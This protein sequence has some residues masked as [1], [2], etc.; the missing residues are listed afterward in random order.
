[1]LLL[2]AAV[3]LLHHLMALAQ[4]IAQA[5]LV[6][7]GHYYVYARNVVE[8]RALFDLEAPRRL[9]S[10]E[11]IEY[12]GSPPNNPPAFYVALTPLARLPYRI[13]AGVWLLL[14]EVLLVVALMWR[15][16]GAMAGRPIRLAI[17]A[18]VVVLFQ[19]LYE[20]LAVGQANLAVLAGLALT[21]R[22][23][24]RGSAWTGAALALVMMIKP[25][26]GTLAVLWLRPSERRH[27]VVMIG[28]ALGLALGSMAVV[29]AQA[30][31]S[32]AMYVRNLP[33]QLTMYHENIS[34]R[35]VFFRLYGHCT[36]GFGDA[37]ALGASLPGALLLGGLA[38]YLYRRPPVDAAARLHAAGLVLC[39]VLLGSPYTWEHHLTV[40]LLVFA[41]LALDP[42][43]RVH[44]CWPGWL[45]A[46]VL[47]AT[48]YVM[49]WGRYP[50]WHTGAASTLLMVRDLGLV[51]LM[52][53]LVLTLE[54]RAQPVGASG[55]PWSRLPALLAAALGARLA[56]DVA[57][58]FVA[59]PADASRL[60][61]IGG[62][63]CWVVALVLAGRL[64]R[65]AGSVSQA[66]LLLLFLGYGPAL[67]AIQGGQVA[68]VATTGLLMVG[69]MWW[70]GGRPA[71][72][73]A[74]LL[75]AVALVGAFVFPLPV[76]LA[77]LLPFA[78]WAS[79]PGDGLAE[80]G[81]WWPDAA[82]ALVFGAAGAHPGWFS[83]DVVEPRLAALGP[84]LRA[85]GL[86]LA[87]ALVVAA[88]LRGA[89]S[90]RLVRS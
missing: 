32:Y 36:D 44:G 12:T 21:V 89:S 53:T 3:L 55:R 69:I 66:A 29:G 2:L 64:S 60:A 84:F 77:T 88:Q 51:V 8:G 20:S 86:A 15:G 65:E 80:P 38:V 68:A 78:A 61:I 11:G 4:F 46:Y 90:G 37:F 83:A 50:A 79:S 18:V 81:P 23:W 10:L 54:R 34:L 22:L 42:P 59:G 24:L 57:K 27:L 85:A 14:S 45:A 63:A 75:G 72:D 52:V 74:P 6:D 30:W 16:A 5:R 33:C 9:R 39:A 48:P 43:R 76:A 26:F 70:L 56:H 82:W 28:S 40:L 1:M 49:A 62:A 13:A 31:V 71:V 58:A 87:A 67:A 41:G 35:S 25:Q 19:P 47:L 73:P 7:F 17:L